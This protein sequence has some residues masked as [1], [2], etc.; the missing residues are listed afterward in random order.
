MV[1]SSLSDLGCRS[2]KSSD[3]GQ[4]LP[5]LQCQYPD[6]DQ[7]AG[8]IC[9]D[10]MI[11]QPA[12]PKSDRLLDNRTYSLFATKSPRHW[13]FQLACLIVSDLSGAHFHK[14]CVR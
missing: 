2:E 13:K 3:R 11:L 4:I 6:I 14:E 8:E 9:T 5:D 1:S 10:Q 12:T 7:E